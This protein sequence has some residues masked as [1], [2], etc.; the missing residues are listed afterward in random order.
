MIEMKDKEQ[1]QYFWRR[2][3]KILKKNNWLYANEI[4]NINSW[5]GVERNKERSTDDPRQD[6]MK[7]TNMK[8]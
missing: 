4:M 3:A 2:I 7:T 8:R 5:K 1:G 6:D